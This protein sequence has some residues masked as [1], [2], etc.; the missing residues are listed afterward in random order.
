[1]TLE[2]LPLNLR[3]TAIVTNAV[4]AII[5]Y[6]VNIAKGHHKP[7]SEIAKAACTSEVTVRNRSKEL[8]QKLGLD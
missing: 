5:L 4:R 2:T 3:R 8:R 1:M 7:Q 6:P